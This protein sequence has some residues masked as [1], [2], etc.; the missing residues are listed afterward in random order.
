MGDSLYAGF[1]AG[2]KNVH[3]PVDLLDVPVF[4]AH[5]AL[6]KNEIEGWFGDYYDQVQIAGTYN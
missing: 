6:V 4:L 3:R 1:K 5:R 2:G